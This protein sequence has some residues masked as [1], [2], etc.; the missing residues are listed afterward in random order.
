MRL[1]I[2]LNLT[3]RVFRNWQTPVTKLCIGRTH[4]IH[5]FG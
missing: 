5:R 4:S 1:L 2:D 3:L